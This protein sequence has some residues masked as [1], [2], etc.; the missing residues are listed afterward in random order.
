MAATR[1]TVRVTPLDSSEELSILKE[2]LD[3]A[4]ARIE[5]LELENDK[6]VAATGRFK[7]E[8]ERLKSVLS[9]QSL[10]ESNEG[11]RLKEE[12]RRAEMVRDQQLHKVQEL[13]R[14]LEVESEEYADLL[15]RLGEMQK[16]LERQCGSCEELTAEV[17]RF[18]EVMRRKEAEDE[19]VKVELDRARTRFESAESAQKD[20]IERVAELEELVGERDAALVES[21]E[22][23]EKLEQKLELVQ[24]R[25]AVFALG[26][27]VS[28]E[29]TV[30]IRASKKRGR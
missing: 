14:A 22:E 1:P 27:T 11:Q 6:H 23:S 18:N 5:A 17:E 25:F 3:Q 24:R 4:N 29:D 30:V 7:E 15:D 13:E 9:G 19:T 16:E 20:L 28:N 8:I 2:E 21:K 12:L 10:F 26:G